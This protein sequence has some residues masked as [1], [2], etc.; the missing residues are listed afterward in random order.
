MRRLILMFSFLIIL[1]TH[2]AAGPNT[3]TLNL[4][5]AGPIWSILINP[6]YQQ[7]MYAASN[8][9]GIYKSTDGG[10]GWVP[11]N[12]GLLNLSI[13][14]AAMSNNNPDVIYCGTAPTGSY[15]GVFKTTNAGATWLLLPVNG[16][17]ETSIG[18]Q[19]IAVD[20]TNQNIVF[21]SVYDPN[22][23][24]AVNGLYKTTNGGT[25]WLPLTSGIGV[26]KNFL[27]IAINPF[28]HLVVYAG[29]TTSSSHPTEQA[30]I[31][32]SN[33]GGA[34]WFN[35]SNGLPPTQGQSTHDPVRCLSIQSVDTARLI[36][37]LFVNETVYGGVYLTTN[38]GA[39]W[40][41]RQT[42]LPT[43]AEDYPRA[44]LIRPGSTTEFIVGFGNTSNSGIGVFRTVDAGLNWVNF[45]GGALTGSTTI[46]AL[47]FKTSGDSTLFAGG[48][49][50]TLGSGQGVFA[51]SFVPVS[52]RSE[53]NSI[54]DKFALHQNYP[55]PFNPKTIINFQ[56][57]MF[58]SVRLIIYDVLGKEI[59]MLVNEQLQPRTYEVEFDGTNYPSGV[60][61]YKLTT[62]SLTQ[63]KRMVL[64]K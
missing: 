49:H 2:T 11:V 56:L 42:G 58:S 55:N 1:H 8:T 5:G 36:A 43:N 22:A 57:S 44:I 7:I 6:F 45:N 39:S 59:S 29:T 50:P 23:G 15:R 60:Y 37:G 9:G 41:R 48:A 51:Y 38:G 63:T 35:I 14:A 17:T 52:V 3:W 4:S 10:T 13:Q 25:S 16:I 53:N 40:T 61:F 24:D 30:R 64:I 19:A 20:P 47:N 27:S 34:N 33:D 18:I 12:T 32:R 28:N 46:R 26:T 31:Y 62:N 54:P 21:I